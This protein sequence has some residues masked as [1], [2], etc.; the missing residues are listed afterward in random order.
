MATQWAGGAMPDNKIWNRMN[1]KKYSLA[2]CFNVIVLI[3]TLPH[4]VTKLGTTRNL[5]HLAV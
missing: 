4:F 2:G 3:R 1:R 5:C